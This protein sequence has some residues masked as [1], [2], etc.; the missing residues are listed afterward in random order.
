MNPSTDTWTPLNERQPTAQDWDETH[1]VEVCHIETSMRCVLNRVEKFTW[2]NGWTHW[3]RVE[4]PP[5]PVAYRHN[6]KEVDQY[7]YR[8][9]CGK[10]QYDKIGPEH[11]WHA[12]LAR[13]RSHL[14]GI[15]AELFVKELREISKKWQTGK[16][17]RAENAMAYIHDM[18]DRTAIG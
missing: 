15:S 7:A 11:A 10:W 12:A 8:D 6:Q 2:G 4:L 1:A 18:L 17:T 5:L 13:E 14:G 9:E 16:I 3:R